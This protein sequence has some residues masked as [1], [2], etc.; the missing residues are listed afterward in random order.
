M[1]LVKLWSCDTC[2]WEGNGFPIDDT[3]YPGPSEFS[4]G[5]STLSSAKRANWIGR[6]GEIAAFLRP[7]LFSIIMSWL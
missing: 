7:R 6:R 3:I 5:R 4:S 1:G 2:S